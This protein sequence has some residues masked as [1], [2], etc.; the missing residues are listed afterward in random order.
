MLICHKRIASNEAAVVQAC[1]MSES[2]VHATFGSVYHAS[3]L[4]GCVP[5]SASSS[6]ICKSI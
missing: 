1:H 3:V 5:L 6:F 2:D 4:R